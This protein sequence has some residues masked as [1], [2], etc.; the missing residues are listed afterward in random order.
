[1]LRFSPTVNFDPKVMVTKINPCDSALSALEAY[2]MLPYGL[3][4]VQHPSLLPLG[5]KYK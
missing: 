2:V 4:A 1:M 5:S 3:A